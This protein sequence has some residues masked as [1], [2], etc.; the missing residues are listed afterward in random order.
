M[1]NGGDSGVVVGAN[2]QGA[3]TFD[4]FSTTGDASNDAAVFKIG[5]AGTVQ[6][7]Q[8]AGAPNAGQFTTGLAADSSGLVVAAGNFN[9]S[10]DFTAGAGGLQTAITALD[11]FFVKLGPVAG[12]AYW[13]R[14]FPNATGSVPTAL[15]IDRV[16]RIVFATSLQGATDF[17]SGPLTSTDKDVVIGQLAP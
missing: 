9:V 1:V 13:T 7:V 6:W 8:R 12:V 17:G 2:V 11:R 4:T 15:A 16:G 3:V 14:S 5:A 10:I